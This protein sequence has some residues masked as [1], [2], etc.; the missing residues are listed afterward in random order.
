MA[1]KG[2]SSETR[3]AEISFENMCCRVPSRNSWMLV[4]RELFNL[5]NLSNMCFTLVFESLATLTKIFLNHPDNTL[6]RLSTISS[7]LG[8]FCKLILSVVATFK[9]SVQYK[10]SALREIILRV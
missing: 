4:H 7:H 2:I 9:D 1:K 6:F 10:M 3:V 8:F 5:Q